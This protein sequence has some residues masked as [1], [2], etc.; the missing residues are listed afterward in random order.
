MIGG[1]RYQLTLEVNRQTRLAIDIAR[2]QAEISARKKILA[3]S[4]DPVGSSR[5][6]VLARSQ[7]D[8]LTWNTNLKS[9]AALASQADTTLD[10]LNS[11]FDRTAELMLTASTG[12]QSAENRNT[13]ALELKSIAD[14]VT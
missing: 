4:D 9:A 2:G 7:A 8:R 13:I 11:A 6:S 5:V 1:T 12:T 14:Q 10:A 3:P